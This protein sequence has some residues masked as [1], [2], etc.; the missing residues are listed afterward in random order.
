MSELKSSGK[1]PFFC[2]K[3][4]LGPIGWWSFRASPCF[5][6][7]FLWA[8]L[9]FPLIFFGFLWAMPFSV[10][11]VSRKI[12]WK[13]FFFSK[14]KCLHLLASTTS[15]Y[16]KWELW[17]S[18]D[19]SQQ[20]EIYS[21]PNFLPPHIKSNIDSE[22]SFCLENLLRQSFYFRFPSTFVFDLF[23]VSVQTG[24]YW[25]FLLPIHPGQL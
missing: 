11:A 18:W 15:G 3:L 13:Y 14:W 12:D 23:V 24:T 10:F 9:V 6:I 22:Q 21:P 5:C 4:A 2:I 19:E 16:L 25:R 20:I 8:F 7:L 1:K 17:S